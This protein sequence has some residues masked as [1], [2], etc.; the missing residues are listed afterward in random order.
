MVFLHPELPGF[1]AGGEPRPRVYGRRHTTAAGAAWRRL[2]GSLPR[3]LQQV[4]AAV[5]AVTT[6]AAS[7]SS[8]ADEEGE[9]RFKGCWDCR[10]R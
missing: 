9:V 7:R 1:T 2:C 4:P 5:A 8:G 6:A 3:E 10:S